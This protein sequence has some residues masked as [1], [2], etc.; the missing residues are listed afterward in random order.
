MVPGV[1]MWHLGK[2]VDAFAVG[3]QEEAQLPDRGLVRRAVERKL[4]ARAPSKRVKIHTSVP[5]RP[6]RL[7][8]AANPVAKAAATHR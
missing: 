8:R 6:R 1:P 2:L 5:R 4:D 7:C 3:P